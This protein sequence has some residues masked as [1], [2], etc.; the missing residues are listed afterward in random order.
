MAKGKRLGIR[1]HIGL[2]LFKS[3]YDG[4]VERHKLRTLFGSVRF[5]VI[6]AAATVVA[7][8]APTYRRQTCP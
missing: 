1:K 2:K 7:T 4:A 8:A 5:V 3:L 6:Y